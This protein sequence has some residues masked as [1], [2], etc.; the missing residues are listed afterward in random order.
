MKARAAV[1]SVALVLAACGNSTP[2]YSSVYTTPSSP[3]TTTT[4][5][6]PTPIAQYLDGVG[7][8]G[9][10][11]P[12]DK[13]TDLTVTLPRLPGWTKYNNS[14]F[15]PGT[16]V[17]AKNNTYPTA[18]VM[19]FR[20]NGNFDVREALKHAS[21]DAE[22]SQNFKKLNY[23]DADFDGF[24]S[25]MI[26][27]SYDLNGK[28]LHTYNRVVIPVTPA[29]RFQRYLVQFTVTTL[30]DQAAPQSGDVEAV[31]KGFSVAVK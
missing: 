20:L 11:V 31:I 2:D 7:V 9:E 27:G 6:T 1:L 8:T 5:A 12:L 16:E 18:M 24:P 13:L 22:I 28:R 10:Q 23:S 15:S 3:T 19:V 26:E 21:A 30:A 29:P 17:I 25:S 14:N 4:A